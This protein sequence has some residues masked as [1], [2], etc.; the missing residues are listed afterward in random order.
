ML[1]DSPNKGMSGK[2]VTFSIGVYIVWQCGGDG[3]ESS[4]SYSDSRSLFTTSEEH[5]ATTT[6]A[7]AKKT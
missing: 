7:A 5:D 3:S 6:T 4:S 1:T 2:S